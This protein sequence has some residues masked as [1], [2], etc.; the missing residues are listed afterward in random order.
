M[1]YV[2]VTQKTSIWHNQFSQ[3]NY[4]RKIQALDFLTNV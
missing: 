1:C 3:Q 4:R 2:S